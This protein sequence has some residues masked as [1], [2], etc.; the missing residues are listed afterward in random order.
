MK[1][2]DF[3][4]GLAYRTVSLFGFSPETGEEWR[5]AYEMLLRCFERIGVKPNTI[6]VDDAPGFSDDAMPINVWRARIARHEF[7]V[8]SM[9]SV[10]SGY[11]GRLDLTTPWLHTRAHGSISTYSEGGRFM[12]FS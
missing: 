3:I 2:H 8:P 4:P 5:A 7:P 10:G 9:L 1:L 12:F 6:T 11:L